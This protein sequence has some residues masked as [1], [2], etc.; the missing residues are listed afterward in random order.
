MKWHLNCV[1]N[2]CACQQRELA[3]MKQFKHS[4][5]L[6]NICV[7]Q[8][9]VSSS[10]W[11]IKKFIYILCQTLPPDY[12]GNSCSLNYVPYKEAGID[13]EIF[14]AHSLRGTSTTV[15][16]NASVTLQE[17]MKTTWRKCTQ[18][19]GDIALMLVY[20]DHNTSLKYVWFLLRDVT[21]ITFRG[22]L[23]L[24]CGPK[25]YHLYFHVFLPSFTHITLIMS[26]G[27]S[28]LM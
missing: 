28:V 20:C 8:R 27:L 4:I 19:L 16:V 22:T 14:K 12:V 18:F 15:A 24:K 1:Y 21:I 2:Y 23:G 17:I 26:E 9:K 25:Q 13:K 11:K 10:R 3:Q 6:I 7:Q 5:L